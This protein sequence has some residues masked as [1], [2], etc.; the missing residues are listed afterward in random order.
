MS[1]TVT[2]NAGRITTSSGPSV[3]AAFAGIAEEAD[4]GG[5]QL[6]VDVRVVDDLAGQEDV[7]PGKRRRAW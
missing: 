1:P 4:A 5:A 3:V 7:R 2:P 6:I